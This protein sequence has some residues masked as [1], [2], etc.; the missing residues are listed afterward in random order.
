MP[1]AWYY[2]LEMRGIHRV[3]RL[4]PGP[5]SPAVA[6]GAAASAAARPMLTAAAGNRW[7]FGRAIRALST[8][9]GTRGDRDGE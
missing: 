8:K 2:P 6:T 5:I 4:L 7:Y 1:L 3:L 9:A